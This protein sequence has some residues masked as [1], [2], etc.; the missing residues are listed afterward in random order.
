MNCRDEEEGEA[1]N[2]ALLSYIANEE[3]VQQFSV[4]S[5]LYLLSGSPKDIV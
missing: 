3:P 4:M 5:K 2:F 1:V